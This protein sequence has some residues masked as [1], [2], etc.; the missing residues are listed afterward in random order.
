[1]IKI[2]A[3]L[4]FAACAAFAGEPAK[5]ANNRAP[6]QNTV[7][8]QNKNYM[9]TAP[10]A[11]SRATFYNSTGQKTGSA[12]TSPQGVTTF[13][14]TSSRVTGRAQQVNNGIIFTDRVNRTQGKATVTK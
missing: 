1:M 3:I 6:V 12:Q 7:P 14:D 13:R 11:N 2:T 4:V 9:A 10:A 8:I 5:K